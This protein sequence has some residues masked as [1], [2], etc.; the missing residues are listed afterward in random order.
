MRLNLL[1][2]L[3]VCANCFAQQVDYNYFITSPQKLK[4]FLYENSEYFSSGNSKTPYFHGKT[5]DIIIRFYETTGIYAIIEFQ[6]KS[7]FL[8]AIQKIKQKA[9]FD[10]KYCTDYSSNISYNY[11]TNND[12]KIRFNFSDYKISLQFPSKLNSYIDSNLEFLTV[13]I[14]MS[15]D[16]YAYHTNLRCEGLGNCDVDIGKSNIKQAKEYGFRI[17]EIC[18]NDE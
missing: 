13:F 8:K 3:L 18:T 15:K 5:N 12:N 16:A 7:E 10:F 9:I 6:S 17:C 1:V 4:S 2:M 11:R 14:C